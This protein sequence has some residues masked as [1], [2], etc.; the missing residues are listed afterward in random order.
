MVN[1]EDYFIRLQKAAKQQGAGYAGQQTDHSVGG[2]SVS[3]DDYPVN[4]S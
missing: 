4:P 3:D 2:A 1:M